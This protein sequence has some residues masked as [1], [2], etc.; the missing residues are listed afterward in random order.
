MDD[1]QQNAVTALRE[2]A[3]ALSVGDK[4]SRDEPK[5]LE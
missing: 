2:A 5:V 3:Q 1:A 4:A